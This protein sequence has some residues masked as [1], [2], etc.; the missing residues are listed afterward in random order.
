MLEQSILTDVN[1]SS[2]RHTNRRLACIQPHEPIILS[3]NHPPGNDT[4]SRVILKN[5]NHIEVKFADRV[6]EP[7]NP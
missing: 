2:S 5:F 6:E 1:D 7:S 3:S 4:V